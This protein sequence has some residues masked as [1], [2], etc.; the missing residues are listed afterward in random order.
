M[1][2]TVVCPSGAPVVGVWVQSTGG[3]SKF[4]ARAP[5]KGG[6][7]MS[8]YS[9]RVNSGAVELHVGCGGTPAKWASDQWT[10]RI[11]VSRSRSVNAICKGRAGTFRRISCSLPARPKIAAPPTNGFAKGNCTQYAAD[12]WRAATGRFPSWRGDAL[13][14][15]ENAAAHRWTVVTKPA[16]RS[17]V[18]F[19]PGV[20]RSSPKYGHVAWVE[21]V[22]RRSGAWY[23]TITEMNFRALGQR[24]SR[25]VKHV[26]GMSYIWAP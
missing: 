8:I 3:G 15:N 11:T 4:A 18:V 17:V 7:T 22:A 20:Q 23:V 26:S 25:T 21:S 9:A 19:E 14:W 1:S 16:A 24:T 5:S 6:T 13:A 10:P 2:G 12:K